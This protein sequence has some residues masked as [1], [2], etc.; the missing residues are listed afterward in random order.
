M[1][2]KNFSEFTRFSPKVSNEEK[3]RVDFFFQ[4]LYLSSVGNLKST[5]LKKLLRIFNS[6]LTQC[7]NIF[8]TWEG[9]CLNFKVWS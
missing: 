2:R 1:S 8:G 9:I 5:Q 6:S 4:I 3:F 7:L